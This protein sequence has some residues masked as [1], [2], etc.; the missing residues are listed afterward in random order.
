MKKITFILLSCVSIG[1][2]A[3]KD[4]V[5]IGTTKPDQSAV[6]DVSSSNKGF[7][8]PRLSLEQRNNI[9]NPAKGLIVYQTDMLSGFYYYDGAKWQPLASNNSEKSV[10][11]DP[12]DWTM[13]GNS[14]AA[15]AF[16]GTNNNVDLEFKAGGTRAGLLSVD[17]R[18]FYGL[19][20]GSNA[21]SGTHNTGIGFTALQ[22]TTTG[23]RNTAIGSRAL[24]ANTTGQDNLALGM[25]ALQLNTTGGNNTAIGFG[26]LN[27]NTVGGLNVA[28]GA[29]A[30]SQQTTGNYNIGLGFGSGYANTTGSG[31]VSIGAYAL[32]S[33]S[34]TSNNLAI[35]FEAG[36]TNNGSGN[37]FIG[38]GAGKDAT[39]VSNKLFIANTNTA[40]PL[41]YGDLS[42]DFLA[43][44]GV[45][46]TAAKRDNLS[47]SYG[48]LVRKG[49]LT[50]KIKVATMTSTDWADYVFENDYKVMP[51]EDVEAFVK[52]N[53]HLPNVPTTTE[54]I[55]NGND[56][57][58]TDAKLLEKI[59]ELTLYMIELNKQVKD[60]KKENE[61]LKKQINK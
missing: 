49:I 9:Q 55:A 42:A 59:E 17:N 25:D 52:E 3:Q 47:T 16:L 8:M 38:N 22:N 10:A 20:A 30:L 7:L 21:A 23:I 4:N 53:K 13:S 61:E 56:L 11:I 34:A 19:L 29:A 18:T 32:F 2:Y 50:E 6:L 5:G 15:G 1:A 60:L 24:N 41:V 51:L 33:G 57:M 54:M 46:A 31:N 37:I 43:V 14:V 58:K 28:I 35:G 36:R 40:T 12:N 45:D 26:A 48:L 44:G 27:L 39:S